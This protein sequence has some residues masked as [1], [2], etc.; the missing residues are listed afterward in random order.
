MKKITISLMIIVAVVF[1]SGCL[2]QPTT[3]QNVCGDDICGINE[4]CN[5]CVADCECASDEYCSDIGI[6]KKYVC[7]DGICSGNENNTCCTDCGCPENQICNKITNQCQIKASISVEDVRSIAIEYMNSQQIAGNVT[8]IIDTYYQ[9]Q[10]CKQVN[11]DCRT[12][13]MPYPCIVILY[14]NDSGDIIEEIR[15]V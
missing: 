14:I 11:I 6:C 7:G 3:V 9:N 13:E 12:K 8:E 4:D 10:S 15:T 5:N 1:V 2:Q